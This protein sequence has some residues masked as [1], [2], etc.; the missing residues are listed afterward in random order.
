MEVSDQARRLQSE[1]LIWDMTLPYTDYG[2]PALKVAMLERMA[3]HGF[4][5]VS[6]TVGGD[7]ME[8]PTTIQSIAKERQYF[9]S[10][11][12]D[13]VLIETADDIVRAKHENKLAVGFHFQGTNPI[14]HNLAM[15]EV[16][17]KLGI[18]HMLMCYNVKTPIGDGCQEQT[19]GGLSRL[20]ADLVREMNRVGMLVDVAHT[21]YRTSMDVFDVSDEPVI[22]SHANARA[23]CDHTRNIKD[24]QIVA[25]A[26]S[27]GVIGVIA[28]GPVLGDDGTPLV[29][30]LIRHIRYIAD[31]V[32]PQHVGLALDLIY[33]QSVSTRTMWNPY[34]HPRPIPDIPPEQMNLII[35]GLLRDGFSE[36]E[37]RGI[38]GE[39][40][41]AVA[42]KV[43]K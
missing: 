34:F 3:A 41:L 29:D 25:C 17:Y 35:E 26:N 23:L 38:L 14:A 33:D 15:V 37:T 2:D 11:P 4:D 24:D 43:W 27:G 36:D 1:A 12:D 19:D 32:G 22:I 28:F 13:Y 30:L 7:W 20:G 21:G 39:N 6:L 8:L 40:W 5:A 18:R 16:Y 31:L 10:R 9:L 42:R